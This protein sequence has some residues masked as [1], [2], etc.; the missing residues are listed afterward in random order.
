MK[1]RIESQTLPDIVLEN[2][3]NRDAGLWIGPGFDTSDDDREL[4]RQLIELP[5][6]IVLCEST[7]GKLAQ[8]LEVSAHSSDRLSRERG[9]VHVVASNPE[10]LELPPRSLPTFFLNGRDDVTNREESAHR[11]SRAMQRRRLNMINRL[12][13]ARPRLLFVLS[14]DDESPLDDVF[15]LWDEGFRALLV[16]LSSTTE[17]VPRLDDWLTSATSAPAVDHCTGPF[18]AVVSS[19]IDRVSAVLPE[20]RFIVKIRIGSAEHDL[21]VTDCELIEQPLF[22]RYEV[23]QARDL[24]Y[25]EPDEVSAE[26]LSSFFD[27]SIQSWRPFAAG[28]PWERDKDANRKLLRALERVAAGGPDQ[29]CVQVI[30]CET[31]AGGTTRAKTIALEAA[32]AGYPALVARSVKFQPKATELETFLY[33]VRQHILGLFAPSRSAGTDDAA[34][35]LGGPD[36]PETPWLLVFDVQHWDGHHAEI[37]VL[38]KALSRSG[39]PAVLLVVTGPD[40]GDELTNSPEVK[41]IERLTHELTEPEALALG[42]HLNRYLKPFGKE[43]S[44]SQWRYF[45]EKHR[46]LD[47]QTEIASFWITLEFWLKGQLDLSESV[48]EWV[49]RHFKE[50]DLTDDVRRLL[51]AIAAL[52]IERQPYPQALIPPSPDGQFPY[53]VVLDD[54]R[55]DVPA[56]A[57]VCD[58]KPP[59]RQWAMAHDLLGRYLITSVYFDRSLLTQLELAA[60]EDPPHLRLMM[61]RSIATRK[62]LE[63]RLL[64]PLAVEFAVNILKLGSD[65]NLDFQRHWKEVLS[66]LEAIPS[67]VWETN[68][69]FNHHVAISRRRIAT[70]DEVFHLSINEKHEQLT[71]A[72]EHLEYALNRV[73]RTDVDDEPDLNLCN[74]LSLAYQNLADVE[75]ARGADEQTLHDLR[76]KATE[77]ARRA[78]HEN[79]TNSYVL[80]TFARNLLQNGRMYPE[81]A[82]VCAAESLGYIYQAMSLDRSLLREGRLTR[83]ANDALSML[84]TAESSQQLDQVCAAGNPLGFLGKAWLVL[85]ENEEQLTRDNMS[86]VPKEKLDTALAVIDKAPTRANSLLLRFRYDLLTTSQPYSFQEQLDLLDELEGTGQALPMQLQLEHAILLH[87]R[88]RHPAANI[89]FKHLRQTIRSQDVYVDVP[90]RLRW[91]LTEDGRQRVCHAR[92]VETRDYRS[93]AKVRELKDAIVPFIAHEF[94][95][96]RMPSG[97][98]FTCAISFGAMGPFIKPPAGEEKGGR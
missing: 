64:I 16:V 72:I 19:L 52:S 36:V 89:E 28:L 22:D 31:G 71:K 2:L 24:P 98:S 79:P 92:V 51:L 6:Q 76:T 65:G 23:I 90:K 74:S 44:E 67:L 15:E 42:D 68:R 88:N 20:D 97:M 93:H 60:A 11:S 43:K 49:A 78:Q 18:A 5:W 12:E 29:N 38:A 85:A 30:A 4:L 45:W 84:R 48:Q 63:G 77:A 26:D 57:L 33:R 34:S 59:L 91:L 46:P 95:R 53:S 55:S 27:R 96:N 14:A 8:S 86:R 10:G 47:M 58:G 50:A 73:E 9:F 83:L 66:I 56:L 81:E 32:R 54:V 82:T 75:Q 35:S 41:V 25:L 1:K 62:E 94:G 37:P 40:I 87:Q 3:A 21:D 39:R 80:E 7:S 70:N 69:T 17:D 61:L 13:L